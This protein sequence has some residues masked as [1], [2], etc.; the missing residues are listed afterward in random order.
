M[1][2]TLLYSRSDETGTWFRYVL[3]CFVVLLVQ[4]DPCDVITHILSYMIPP[5]PGK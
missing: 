2:L 3:F 4:V 5:V 1:K